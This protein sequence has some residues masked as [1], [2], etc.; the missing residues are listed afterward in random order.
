MVNP[1]SQTLPCRSNAGAPGQPGSE[2]KPGGHHRGASSNV[3][4]IERLE[5]KMSASDASVPSDTS[6]VE[7]SKSL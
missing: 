7:Y 6:P 1:S 3:T 5:A 2:G 4:C